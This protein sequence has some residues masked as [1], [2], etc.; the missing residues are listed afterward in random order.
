MKALAA[1]LLLSS[2]AFA[3]SV[4]SDELPPL[5]YLSMPV[6]DYTL[7]A[8]PN[9]Y[10][11]HRECPEESRLGCADPE[12]GAIYYLV[13][14]RDDPVR[15]DCFME[16]EIAHLNGWPGTHPDARWLD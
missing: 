3:G 1:F 13:D 4:C 15:F 5:R 12:T 6:P 2:P 11:V 7:V 8:L 9:L 14:L 16:H 10:A